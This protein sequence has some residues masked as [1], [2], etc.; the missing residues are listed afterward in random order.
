MLE[1]VATHPQSNFVYRLSCSTLPRTAAFN[2]RPMLPRA[3]WLGMIAGALVPLGARS[4][5]WLRMGAEYY[6]HLG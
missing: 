5:S 1:P 3:T 4:G 6:C 2:W